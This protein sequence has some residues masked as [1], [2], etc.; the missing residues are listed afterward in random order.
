MEKGEEVS[1]DEVER[2]LGDSRQSG[3]DIRDSARMSN[4]PQDAL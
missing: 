2:T 1:G 3:H 4:A